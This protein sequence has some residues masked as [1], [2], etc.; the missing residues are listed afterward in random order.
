M[1]LIRMGS[2]NALEQTRGN[3]FWKR[4]IG[5]ALPSADTTGRVF[6]MLDTNNIRTAIRYIY[7]RLKRNKALRP[8][9]HG[10]FALIIDGHESSASYLRCCDQCLQRIIHTKQG[11]RIQYYHRNV[12]AMLLCKDFPVLLDIE[13]QRPHEDEVAAATRLLERVLIN[14]PRA[15]SLIL[16]DGLYVRANF[17]KLALNYGKDIIAVL[18]DERRDL[19]QD[20]HGIFRTEES[21][22]YQRGCTMRECWDIEHF[23]SWSQIDREVRVV[24]SLETTTI[25]RQRTKEEQ[26]Q[27]TDWVWV[28]NISKQKLSTSA[29]ID[30]GHSR[31]VIENNELNELVNYWH[32]DHVYKH[33]LTAIE[34]FWLVIMMAYNLFHAFIYLNLKPEIR[35]RYTKLHWT[36]VIVAELYCIP[37]VPT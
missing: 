2:L 22:I 32:A 33:H 3:Y 19:L 8:R 17:F 9:F 37:P 7:S 20:A 12:T 23:T 30:F 29:F 31:W 34:A 18:K 27:V 1:A 10:V 13:M 35:H 5:K 15:F 25:R 14:Y 6:A 24:R 26:Q 4:W 11:D 16:A 21:K 28:S 36:R